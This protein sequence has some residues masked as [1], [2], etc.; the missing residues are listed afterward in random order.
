MSQ[1]SDAASRSGQR[2]SGVEVEFPRN[3][4]NRI[5]VLLPSGS[6]VDEI[7]LTQ[8]EGTPEFRDI[9]LNESRHDGRFFDR[10]ILSRPG[11]PVVVRHKYQNNSRDPRFVQVL[12]TYR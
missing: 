12:V 9:N 7:L 4:T 8:Q 5:D 3:S 6:T 10:E 11:Q 1:L 2:F